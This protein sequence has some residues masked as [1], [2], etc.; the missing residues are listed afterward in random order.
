MNGSNKLD[1]T[2][3]RYPVAP[4]DGRIRFLRLKVKVTVGRRGGDGTHVDASRSLLY[5]LVFAKYCDQRVCMSCRSV[6]ISQ[7]HTSKFTKF[8]ILP[9]AMARCSFDSGSAIRYVLPVL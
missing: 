2:G 6:R 8:S 9:V 5:F 1:E 4:N 7:K 3:R